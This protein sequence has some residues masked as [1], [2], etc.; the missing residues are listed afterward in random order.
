[1]CAQK[2]PRFPGTALYVRTHL[3]LTLSLTMQHYHPIGTEIYY[4]GDVANTPAF[5]T[6]TRLEQSSRFGATY[7]IELEDGRE[8]RGIPTILLNRST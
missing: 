8:L 4:A 7:D 6:I 1:M 3:H 5:G 2:P